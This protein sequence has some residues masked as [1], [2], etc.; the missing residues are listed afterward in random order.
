MGRGTRFRVP[1]ALAVAVVAAL[2]PLAL[3]APASALSAPTPWDGKN[4]FNCTIQDAGFGTTVPDPGADPYCVHFDKT[5]QNVAQLGIV[6]FLLEEPARTAAAVPKCFYF[7]ED[8]WR[9]SISQGDGTAIYNFEGHYFFNKATGDGGAWVTDFTVNGQ[10]F[11][12]DSLPGF[13]PQYGQDFGPGTGGFISHDDIPADPGCA[14]MAN[15]SPGSVYAQSARPR[16]L[17]DVGPVR[18]RALGPVAIGAREDSVRAEL[19]PPVLVKRGFL[20]YCVS[21]GGVLAVGQPGDRSGNLGTGGRAPTVILFTTAHGF[22]L[23]G[24]A[25]H[26]VT[27]GSKLRSVRLAFPNAEPIARLGGTR[28]L[29]AGPTI[30]VGERAGRVSFLVV[31]SPKAIGT[32]RKLCGFLARAS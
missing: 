16:C 10:T 1:T 2:L 12:P 24:R 20:R 3:C 32:K 28:V 18:R 17:P 11:N 4:P 22:L 8:H 5:N 23:R 9:G 13:P 26:A 7:Q 6:Q 21:G 27:V 30:V 19:G 25:R 31:Y 29:R 15:G 14:A